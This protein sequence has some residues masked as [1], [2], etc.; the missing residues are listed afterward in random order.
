MEPA[1]VD[2][3]VWRLDILSDRMMPVGQLLLPFDLYSNNKT[4]PPFSVQTIT[5]MYCNYS[6][7]L[8]SC[9]FLELLK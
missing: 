3:S 6:S 4:A 8:T 7:G 1:N 5:V 2:A 9:L